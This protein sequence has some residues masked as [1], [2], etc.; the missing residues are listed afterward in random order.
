MHCNCSTSQYKWISVCNSQYANAS[1]HTFK[2]YVVFFFTFTFGILIEFYNPVSLHGFRSEMSSVINQ[3][4][5][6]SVWDFLK[7]FSTFLQKSLWKLQ[8]EMKKIYPTVDKQ[9][10]AFPTDRWSHNGTDD[11]R[12]KLKSLNQHKSWLK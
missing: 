4:S 2:G 3:V 8:K 12:F 6:H 7:I 10:V 11:F 9:Y 5:P 1:W